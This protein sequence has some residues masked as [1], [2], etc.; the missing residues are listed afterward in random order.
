MKTYLGIAVAL[1]V[2]TVG[3]SLKFFPTKPSLPKFSQIHDYTLF[4]SLLDQDAQ[5]PADLKG[6]V[7]LIDFFFTRCQNPCPMMA[8]RMGE[9]QYKLQA[10]PEIKLVSITFDPRYDNV[11]ILNIYARKYGAD[12]KRW[13]LLTGD[14]AVIMKLA[15]EVLRLAAGEESDLH[16]TRIALIDKE[17]VIRGYYDTFDDQAMGNLLADAKSLNGTL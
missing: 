1:V 3:L 4:A 9:L 6:K 11:E 13:Q 8:K 17:G 7:V 2:I 12:A 14:K 15:N 16:S 5:S 10:H